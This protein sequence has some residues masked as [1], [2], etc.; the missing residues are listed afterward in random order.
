MMLVAVV[1]TVVDNIPRPEMGPLGWN[2]PTWVAIGAVTAAFAMTATAVMAFYT[3]RLAKETR[4]IVVESAEER[5]QLERHH[6]QSLMPLVQVE[7]TCL[8]SREARGNYIRFQGEIVNIG[9]GPSIGINLLLRPSAVTGRWFYLGVIAGNERRPLNVEWLLPS[10]PVQDTSRL[11]YDS[12][13]RFRTVFETEGLVHQRSHSGEAK[14]ALTM[15]FIIPSGNVA[16]DL[17]R[18]IGDHFPGKVDGTPS[19]P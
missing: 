16:R 3:R 12:L 8:L 13:T 4:D 14:D 9:P 17:R 19:L 7:G 2:E 18:I 6:Q 15:D 1:H 10:G 5:A 11:P